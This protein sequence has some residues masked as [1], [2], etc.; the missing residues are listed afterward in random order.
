MNSNKMQLIWLD[1]RQ[2]L[3]DVDIQPLHLHDGIVITSSP[4][5]C[6][7]S[8]TINSE[9]IMTLHVNNLVRT[10]F[11]QLRQLWYIKSIITNIAA[12]SLV[13]SLISSRLNYCNSVKYGASASNIRKMPAV[14]NV[15]ARL[16][17]RHGFFNHITPALRDE[18]H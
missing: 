12:K 8:V 5:A 6:M 9:L 16:I 13:H 11:Y 15:S 10:C 4:L 14:L 1:I 18:L 2:Q 7:L 3:P 17:T